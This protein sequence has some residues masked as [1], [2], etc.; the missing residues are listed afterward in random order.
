MRSS[1][2][3]AGLLGGDL[4]VDSVVGTGSTFTL[5]LPTV[6]KQND[7]QRA[8][9]AI[10]SSTGQ[11][12]QVIDLTQPEK[13]LRHAADPTSAIVPSTLARSVPDDYETLEPGDRSCSWSRTT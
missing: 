7:K 2:E 6:Y 1:R 13:L 8:R 10:R 12:P 11:L 4:R 3:I 5:Y 9:A